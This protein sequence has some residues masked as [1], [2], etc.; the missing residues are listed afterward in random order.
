MELVMPADDVKAKQ[1]FYLRHL[2]KL[3]V[4]SLLLNIGLTVSNTVHVI[5]LIGVTETNFRCLHPNSLILAHF[6]NRYL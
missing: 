2:H 5:G 4:K 6:V 1:V 3:S